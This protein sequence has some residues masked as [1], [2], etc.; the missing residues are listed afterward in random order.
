MP[1]SRHILPPFRKLRLSPW[2]V[3]PPLRKAL[4]RTLAVYARMQVREQAYR[5]DVQAGTW[6]ER[7]VRTRDPWVPVSNPLVVDLLNALLLHR[8]ERRKRVLYRIFPQ[9]RKPKSREWVPGADS[10]PPAP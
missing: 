5:Q 7:R 3:I 4:A 9:V 8:N 10:A 1:D 6:E 2:V